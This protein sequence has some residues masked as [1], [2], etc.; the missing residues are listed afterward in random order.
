MQVTRT[1]DSPTKVTLLISAGADELEP[2][3]RHT[4]GHFAGSVKVPGFRE[5]AVPAAILEKHVDPKALADEFMEHALNSLYGRAVDDEGIRPITPPDVQVKK[6][7]PY[8]TLEFEVKVDILGAIKLPDYKKIKLPKPSVDVEAAE[9]TDVV[10][11]IQK[12]LAERK[13]VD[14][15]AKLGDEVTIDFKGTDAKGK[16]VSGADGEDY[17][18][19]LGSNTFIPGFEDNLIGLKPGEEKTFTL[20]FPQDY[21]V[22]ALQNQKVTFAVGVKKVQELTEPKADDAFA[23]KAGPFKTLA[24]LKADI[25]KQLSV[26]KERDAQR[27]YENELINKIAS[28]AQL[29]VPSSLVDDQ[30][31]AAEE[32]E[33]RNLVYRGQTW[34]EHL[35]E[36]GINEQQHRERHRPAAENMVKTSL[37]LGEIA[38][39]EKVEVTPEELEIRLQLIRGQ[40]SDPAMQAQLDEPQNRRDIE[41]RLRLEKTL[42][43]L[44]EYASK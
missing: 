17:P 13:P 24:E 18:L 7:V 27:N 44:V 2:I 20:A 28:E 22:A 3:K 26:E 8:T 35:E 5:G 21:G 39:R 42:A 12:Q 15:A 14:R 1:N 38:Q 36:E 10:K 30:V 32:E 9:I 33:K 29:D 41:G 37:L 43:K 40:Y 34:Q 6:F 11:S 31:L 25:K 16:P 23:A 4:L 19:S